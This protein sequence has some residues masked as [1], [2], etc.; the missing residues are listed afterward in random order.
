VGEK[1]ARSLPVG[2]RITVQDCGELG[3]VDGTVLGAIPYDGG[4]LRRT[5]IRE[6]DQLIRIGQ[7]GSQPWLPMISFFR[8]DAVY[9]PWT[10][11]VYLAQMPKKFCVS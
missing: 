6:L 4:H 5:Q 11:V 8:N 1:S 7:V 9:S 10:M 2:Q 3:A